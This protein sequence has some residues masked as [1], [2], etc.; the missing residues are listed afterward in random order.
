MSSHRTLTRRVKRAKK[1]GARP[2]PWLVERGITP[3]R[4][5]VTDRLWL[6][7]GLANLHGVP[8]EGLRA[9]LLSLSDERGEP[10]VKAWRVR[11]LIDLARQIAMRE[12]RLPR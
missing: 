10:V 3:D 9:R 1:R 6:R 7:P 4:P 12:K 2:Q 5:S 8:P 11:I